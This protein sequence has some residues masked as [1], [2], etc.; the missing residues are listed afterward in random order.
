M[1]IRARPWQRRHGR[2]R[3]S[4]VL[5][6][7]LLAAVPACRIEPVPINDPGP[8]TAGPWLWQWQ[9]TGRL[10][11]DAPVAVFLLDPVTT[12][13]AETALLRS[14][15]RRLIC[16]VS[17]GSYTGA[18]PDADRFP[19]SVRGRHSDG[20]VRWV[21]VRQWETLKPIIADRLRL[22]LGKRFHAAALTGLD[23]YAHRSGFRLSY[24][25]QIRFN[26]RV[27]ELTRSIGLSPGMV[28]NL[29]QAAA[30]APDF[31]FAVTEECARLGQCAKLLPFTEAGKPVLHVEYGRAPADFCVTGL[32]YGFSSMR[33]NRTLDAWRDPCPLN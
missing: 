18:D 16:Q 6:V 2:R 1:G 33:K 32:G 31:D 15:D 14:R 19:A 22:C 23:G 9:T 8:F 27:A 26:R 10:D 29:E 7:I 4:A 13:S 25:D 24:D 5:L 3:L 12:T 17:A 30:L 28:G 21:D 11:T 20:G